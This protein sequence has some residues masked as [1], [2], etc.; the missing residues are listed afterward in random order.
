MQENMIKCKDLTSPI[1]KKLNTLK[2]NKLLNLYKLLGKKFKERNVQ[3]DKIIDHKHK[4]KK[5]KKNRSQ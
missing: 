1:S 4:K 3:K 2:E 5:K